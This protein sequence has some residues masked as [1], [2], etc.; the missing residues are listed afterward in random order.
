MVAT[1]TIR[2][3]TKGNN[4]IIDI[5]DA[6]AREVAATGVQDGL[7]AVFVVGSTVGITTVEYEPGLVAD[8]KDAFD[9]LIPR[10]LPYRHNSTWNE[11]NGHSHVR[12]S[13]LGP[14]LALPL[15]RGRLPLGTWQQIIL[16]DFDIR[17]R[18]REVIVQ[19]VGDSPTGQ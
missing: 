4:D 18:S 19:V 3:Q 14:S 2:L 5:T 7:V 15:I 9:Q 10:G 12:A 6:V 13:L 17:P 11:D 1:K 16:I 8:L